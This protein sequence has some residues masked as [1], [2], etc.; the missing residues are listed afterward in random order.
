MNYQIVNIAEQ[1]K[2]QIDA[3]RILMKTFTDLG[4]NTW[5]DIATAMNEI[6][7]CIDLPNICIGIILDNYLV[8]LVGLRPMYKET[9][10]LH[11]LVIK[12]EYQGK[13][14]GK[15]LLYELEIRAKKQGLIGIV[16]GT[17]DENNKT[18]L[19][20]LNITE[21]NIFDSIINIKNINKH[22]YE[23]YKKNGYIIVGVIP[24]ANG[25]NKP[26]IWM[27]KSLL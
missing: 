22:P 24:N 8:G 19:S 20:Q 18:S 16:L 21:T 10:E 9:W 5:P 14:L 17:D 27:W 6:D 12:K 7:E 3:A 11:P 26:D 2:Y 15:K 4:N 13:G 23:F 1:S 25:K